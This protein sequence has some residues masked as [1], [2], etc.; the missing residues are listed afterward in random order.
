MPV[1][2]SRVNRLLE[3]T[4]MTIKTTLFIIGLLSLVPVL[5]A[6][7]VNPARP[8]KPSAAPVVTAAAAT[9]TPASLPTASPTA[10]ALS[11]QSVSGGGVVVTVTPLTLALGQPAT[12]DISMNSHSVEIVEDMVAATVLRDEAG[13]QSAAAAWEGAGPGGHHREGVI[14]FP[15][16]TGEP[17]EVVLIVKDVAKVPVREFRWTM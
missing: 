12:F 9:P 11:T 15:P 1:R 14:R 3:I 10:L 4:T 2:P 13:N 17:A 16:L 5:A 7:A 6:C 8:P